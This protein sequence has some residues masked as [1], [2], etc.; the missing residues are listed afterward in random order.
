[1]SNIG[2]N[3]G[4]VYNV[5]SSPLSAKQL[6]N[7]NNLHPNQLI[8]SNEPNLDGT[9]TGVS[10]LIATDRNGK[11]CD[12]SNNTQLTNIC[13]NIGNVI[14]YQT[15]TGNNPV[16]KY[17]NNDIIENDIVKSFNKYTITPGYIT[18]LTYTSC[19]NVDVSLQ[20]DIFNSQ[21]IH[22][23]IVFNNSS[24][25]YFIEKM[26]FL[27]SP[28]IVNNIDM[29]EYV[30]YI[31]IDTNIPNTFKQVK[32]INKITGGTVK[33][34]IG[35]MSRTL[36]YVNRN[37]RLFNDYLGFDDYAYTYYMLGSNASMFN[38]NNNPRNYSRDMTNYIYSFTYTI[39]NPDTFVITP[40]TTLENIILTQ[41]SK[42]SS[43]DDPGSLFIKL[44][45]S[46][47][48]DAMSVNLSY[49]DEYGLTQYYNITSSKLKNSRVN[50]GLWLIMPKFMDNN[51]YSS[52]TINGY[53]YSSSDT[54]EF[55]HN[56]Q[57]YIYK[58]YFSPYDPAV[59]TTVHDI[60]ISDIAYIPEFTFTKR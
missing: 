2:I 35:I 12:V 45:Q 10:T 38:Y 36:S 19:F 44:F 59:D 48:M 34:Y 32:L 55:T 33:L 42:L 46:Y 1:M 21:Q 25:S 13:N 7:S 47:T 18:N 23:D 57:Q 24:Y 4:N 14:S 40:E 20:N 22:T 39:Y 51:Y 41:N 56:G 17:T 37:I 11:P 5:I 15:F 50:M 9:D 54:H 30:S 6:L 53:L 58:E 31:N 26:Y 52:L 16:L 43:F 28:S 8:I 49:Y 29:G 3:T 27:P 60:S